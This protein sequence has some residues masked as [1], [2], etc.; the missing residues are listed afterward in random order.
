[1]GS[2]LPDREQAVQQPPLPPPS[3]GAEPQKEELLVPGRSPMPSHL[4]FLLVPTWDPQGWDH[5][6]HP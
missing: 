5:Q 1:M 3:F 6:V 4:D 2:Q